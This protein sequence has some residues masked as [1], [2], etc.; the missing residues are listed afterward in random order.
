MAREDKHKSVVDVKELK[1]SD[2]IHSLHIIVLKHG[3]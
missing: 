1:S 3:V 2:F